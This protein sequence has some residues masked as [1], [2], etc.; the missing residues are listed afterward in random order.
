MSNFFISQNNM[1]ASKLATS[2]G[3]RTIEYLKEQLIGYYE[4]GIGCMLQSSTLRTI[5]EPVIYDRHF[6]IEPC[7]GHVMCAADIDKCVN[8]ELQQLCFAHE[9]LKRCYVYLLFPFKFLHL[10]LS[11][12]HI[13]TLKTCIVEALIE[14]GFL[15]LNTTK[16]YKSENLQV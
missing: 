1:F 11:E 8:I 14:T 5:L 4:I 3:A 12:Y 9:D 15:V 16:L 6:R 7:V 10:S 13:V 2:Q